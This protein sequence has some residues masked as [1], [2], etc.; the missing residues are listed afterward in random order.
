[1]D[2]RFS[3]HNITPLESMMIDIQ[4]S[5][6]EKVWEYIETIKNP[7]SRCNARNLFAQ[8]IKKL[9]KEK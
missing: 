1:M 9:N 3:F 8:A 5:G 6:K 7:I 4:D 2:S